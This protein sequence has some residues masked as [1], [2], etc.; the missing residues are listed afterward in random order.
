MEAVKE[1]FSKKSTTKSKSATKIPSCEK[2]SK[3]AQFMASRP[4]KGEIINMR[5]ILR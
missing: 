5:A 4:G 3:I 2:L 1:E